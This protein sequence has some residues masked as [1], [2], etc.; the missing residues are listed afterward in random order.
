VSHPCTAKGA[1]YLWLLL[2]GNIEKMPQMTKNN[3]K[4]G[5]IQQPTKRKKKLTNNK[6]ENATY[7]VGQQ[8]TEACAKQSDK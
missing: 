2:Q 7:S 6:Q 1:E 4:T 8:Q 3:R 5:R